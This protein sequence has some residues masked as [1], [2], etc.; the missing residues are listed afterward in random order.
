MEIDWIEA[1]TYIIDSISFRGLD[2]VSRS[3]KERL[4]FEAKQ[5]VTIE[6]R[7]SYLL[8]NM[9]FAGEGQELLFSLL[10]EDSTHKLKVDGWLQLEQDIELKYLEGTL[11]DVL[12]AIM[13]LFLLQ[14]DNLKWA[15]DL[16][17][18]LQLVL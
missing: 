5:S 6:K 14:L 8:G 16:A 17:F 13:P 2:T 4:A 11:S 18:G 9:W 7:I 10:S 1:L 15:I 12:F 3:V